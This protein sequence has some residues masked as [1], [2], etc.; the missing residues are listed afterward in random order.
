M[1]SNKGKSKPTFLYPLSPAVFE[2]HVQYNS[3]ALK[4]CVKAS[5][6]SRPCIAI[7]QLQ[8]AHMTVTHVS[9]QYAA[10]YTLYQQSVVECIPSS[11]TVSN[12]SMPAAKL[13]FPASFASIPQMLHHQARRI[14]ESETAPY[15]KLIRQTSGSQITRT[16]T[17]QAK[18]LIDMSTFSLVVLRQTLL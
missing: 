15:K 7:L 17:C 1:T 14:W 3:S 11:A 18:I 12:Y 4:L 6:V 2:C 9:A 10:V 8:A 13:T 16:W 5:A